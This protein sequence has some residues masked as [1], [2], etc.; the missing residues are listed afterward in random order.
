[1]GFALN[2]YVCYRLSFKNLKPQEYLNIV[3]KEE[4]DEIWKPVIYIS[5]IIDAPE[6]YDETVM[7]KG[8]NLS[9]YQVSGDHEYQNYYIYNGEDGLVSHSLTLS[10]TLTCD[11]ILNWYPYDQQFCTFDILTADKQ[12]VLIDLIANGIEYTG[13]NKLSSHEVEFVKLC[14]FKFKN[15]TGI[16]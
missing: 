4:A 9:D 15:D 14:Q 6:V 12:R 10:S 16:R 11:F 5:N 3:K 8:H 1:M 2:F 7:I 13:P